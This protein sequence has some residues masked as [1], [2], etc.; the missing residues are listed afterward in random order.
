[1]G[2]FYSHNSSKNAMQFF[3]KGKILIMGG[4]YDGK[5][6]I[7]HVEEK[8]QEIII[9]FNDECPIL[10]VCIS[11]DEEYLL[12]GNSIGNVALYKIDVD[13]K[14]WSLIKKITSQKREISHIHCNSDL[15]LWVSTTIDGFINLYTLPLCKLARTIKV[16]TKKCS[17]SFLTSAPLPSIVIINDEANS[18]L[19]VYSING[20]VISKKELYSKLECPII[21]KDLN[22]NEYLGYIG[23]D[24]ICI[25]NLP[26]L[27]VV[28]NINVA[29]NLG[30][31]TIFTSED[32]KYLYCLNK[33]G[34]EVYIIRDEFKK[35]LRNASL[36]MA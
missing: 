15:N 24:H 7:Y 2:E 34:S 36:I 19:N 23:K 20:K 1:M 8:R 29:P 35:N 18:E 3:N 5:I 17:Y 13:I 9:P 6:V 11:K 4:F 14:K 21:I 22:S 31:S 33:S 30:I 16:S 25:H 26:L 10:S 27:E 32:N 28:F 12:A